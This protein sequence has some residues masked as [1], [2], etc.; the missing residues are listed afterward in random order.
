VKK[1]KM[2]NK[3]IMKK[4]ATLFLVL[5]MIGSLF[6]VTVTAIESTSAGDRL[7]PSTADLTEPP[8]G[9][10]PSV[11]A[12]EVDEGVPVLQEGEDE[13]LPRPNHPPIDQIPPM[14]MPQDTDE[15][16][17]SEGPGLGTLYNAVTGETIVSPVDETALLGG[18]QQGGGYSGT[19]GGEGTEELPM[20]FYDMYKITNTGAFPWRMNAKLLMRFEDASGNDHWYTCSGTMRDAETVLTAGHCVYDRTHGYG[21]AKEIKVYPGWDGDDTSC[22]A[23]NYGYGRGTYFGSWTGWTQNGDLNYDVGIIGVTRAVGM[24]TG[25]YGWAYGGSCDWHK[26]Q[27]YHNPSYPAECC[28]PP[29][30]TLHNGKDMYYWYGHFDSCPSWNRLQID[31]SGGCFN[32]GWGGMSGS[33]AYYKDGDNRYVHAFASTS[34]RSTFTRYSRQWGDWVNWNNNIF[35]PN[36]RGSAFDLQALDVNAE[37]ATIETGGS[38]TLLNHLATNPTNGNKAAT[39]TVRV[40]LSTNDLISSADTLLSTQYLTYTFNPMSSVRV[41]MVQVT[42]PSNTPAGDYWIGVIYDSAT[43][44]NSANND[45]SCW[46]AVPIHVI[47]ETTPPSVTVTSPNGGE[48]WQVGSTQTITWTATDNVGVT[49]IDIKYSTN[50]GT[51]YPYT[52]ATGI[53]NTGSRSWTVPNTPSTTCKVKVIAHDAAGNTGEDASNSNFI[54]FKPSSENEVYLVPQ[55]SSAGFCNTKEVQIWANTTDTFGF[56]QINLT[57]THCCA[58]VT[59]WEYGPLWQGTWDTRFDGKEW[60]VFM[61]PFGQPTVNGTLLIG[62]L[63]IHCCN[64]SDCET[65]LT[66]SPPS[67]LSDPIAGDLTV[68]WTDGTFECITGVCGDVAPYPNCDGDVD[69]SD[70]GL[71]LYHVGFPGDPRYPLCNEWAADVNCDGF[72]DVSDVGR[73]LYHVGF[74][75]DPNYPLNCC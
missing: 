55:H 21:W 5:L 46:D 35:I 60:L 23:E 2:R 62:T 67:K 25:W 40:Y 14:P 75:G 22:N 24:L 54:I 45:A 17:A 27:T 73:L 12:E 50:G 37:P 11:E 69:V 9:K 18:F 68:T 7:E 47:K 6:G 29:A 3:K 65:P 19:D 34:D 26:S 52:I 72:I 59:N 57:Y 38:T 20:T 64:E 32:A 74:P 71:L 36:V 63:T 56:G 51:T 49:S 31:T 53:S 39:F 1:K 44:G 15:L 33:G 58:N 4:I 70:V 28:N 41:N 13:P 43:D 48:N 8:E 42:I 16:P 66:F 10:V 61:R 30:C